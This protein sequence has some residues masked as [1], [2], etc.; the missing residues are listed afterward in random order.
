MNEEYKNTLNYIF[1]SISGVIGTTLL[2]PTYL[3]KRVLQTSIDK[4]SI[5]Q[6]IK[7]IYQKDRIYGFY[8]GLTTCYMKVI[9]YQGFLFWS[10]EKL[11]KMIKY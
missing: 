9:P 5:R 8:K 1:G 4:L 11:K 10:N 2:Y 6:H 3:L 7:I